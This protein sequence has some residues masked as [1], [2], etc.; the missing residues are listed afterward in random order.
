MRAAINTINNTIPKKP[1]NN[2][3]WK[4]KKLEKAAQVQIFCSLEENFL[5]SHF[6]ALSKLE[7]WKNIAEKLP[8]NSRN[9]FIDL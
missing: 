9:S 1:L 8:E 2:K 5:R 3:R 6:L 4:P 7:A